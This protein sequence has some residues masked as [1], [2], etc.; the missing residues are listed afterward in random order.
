MKMRRAISRVNLKFS[1]TK[2]R[3]ESADLK[4][5]QVKSKVYKKR[6][7]PGYIKVKFQNMKDK[8]K[9]KTKQNKPSGEWVSGE[10]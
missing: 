10:G 2:E 6:C 3:Q 9:I 5:P 1:G 8:E 4:C 7:I